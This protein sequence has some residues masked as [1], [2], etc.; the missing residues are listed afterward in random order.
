MHDLDACVANGKWR[1]FEVRFEEQSTEKEKPWQYC[2]IN[3][4]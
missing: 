2:N 4:H 3:K 1:I